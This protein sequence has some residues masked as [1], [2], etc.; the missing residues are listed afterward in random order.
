MQ[1]IASLPAHFIA[2]YSGTTPTRSRQC[3]LGYDSSASCD[4]YQLGETLKFLLKRNLITL[5]YLS[6]SSSSL[7][8]SQVPPPDYATTEI[9]HLLSVLKQFPSYQIDKNHTNCGPRTRLK[10]ILEFLTAM[11]GHKS[12]SISR[13]DWVRRRDQV[14]WLLLSSTS[15]PSILPEGD[16][17]NGDD[18]TG[19][20]R[21]GDRDSWAPTSSVI[22]NGKFRP[23]PSPLSFSHSSQVDNS[24]SSGI[25][26]ID[27]GE[28]TRMKKKFTFTRSMAGDQ[29][30]RFEGSMGADR[31]VRGLFT[32]DEWDWTPEDS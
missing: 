14:S 25:G 20:M 31:L 6:P 17:N 9:T 32:A 4:S 2:L 15:S 24:N 10:P 13:V 7:P 3:K 26:R 28:A 29:R 11:V 30:L 21:E 8:C 5:S 18:R 22:L 1:T 12:V 19:S 27:D 16:F 23:I